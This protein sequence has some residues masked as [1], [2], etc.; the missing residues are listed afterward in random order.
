MN[1]KSH[2]I[3]IDK[4]ANIENNLMVLHW[5]NIFSKYWIGKEIRNNQNIYLPINIIVGHK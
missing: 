5:S 3:I 4:L 1:Y 2:L